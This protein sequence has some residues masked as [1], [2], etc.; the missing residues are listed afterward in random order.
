M[1][2]T[3]KPEQMDENLRLLRAEIEQKTGRTADE[4]Y[5]EREKRIRDAVEANQPDRV[6]I[7]IMGLPAQR[8]GGPPREAMRR[9]ALYF[10][11]DMVQGMGFMG[12]RPLW[13]ALDIK[14]TVWPGHGLPANATGHQVIEGEWMKADEYDH[15]L[16][17]PADFSVRYYLPRIYGA[18]APLA[19]LPPLNMLYS[20]GVEGIAAL[21]ATPEFEEM[22]K[23]L[24]KAGKEMMKSRTGGG[25]PSEDLALLGF[26][27]FSHAGGAPRG[28]P[29]DEISA[30][31]RGMKGSM[32][33]MYQRPEKLLA[34]CDKIADM[35]IA[36][37]VPADPTKRG[38]PKRV[39][40]P[41]WRGDQTFMSQKQFE[42]FYWPGLK[43]VMQAA[44]DLGY[45][46]MPFFEAGFGDRLE[47]LL[48]LPKG[49]VIASVSHMD[50]IRA[51]EIL[52]GHTCVMGQG[53]SSLRYLSLKEVGE[54]YQNMVRVAGKGGG[55]MLWMMLPGKGTLEELKAVVDSIKEAG[56]V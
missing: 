34:A 1:A 9:A 56:R 44:I 6:P 17:D 51:K 23:A 26:P 40:M 27:P 21:A 35:Q 2:I 32:L 14:N 7:F 38:N 41:L 16:K 24:A 47:C 8:F 33:D 18:L 36:R 28:A 37:A 3:V 42:K 13:E 5:E 53:P 25:N 54:Y 49:K 48:E 12:S 4:W 11:P 10:E 15:F 46:P 22:A 20:G 45:V 50:V 43:K 52:G 31:L 39:G 55:F 19:K 30:H 29:F